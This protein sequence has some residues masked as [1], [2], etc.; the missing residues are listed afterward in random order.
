[1]KRLPYAVFLIEPHLFTDGREA[2]EAFETLLMVRREIY[3]RFQR[4]GVCF[5]IPQMMC[6][7]QK[8]SSWKVFKTYS[9]QQ[10]QRTLPGLGKQEG[11]PWCS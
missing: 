3:Q 2:V 11:F 5:R 9:G 10:E 1:M 4:P 6:L 8:Q 7:K